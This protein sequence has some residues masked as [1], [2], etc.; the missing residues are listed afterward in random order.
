MHSTMSRSTWWVRRAKPDQPLGDDCAVLG[1]VV[2]EVRHDRPPPVDVA[3]LGPSAAR[4]PVEGAGD[5]LHG[6]GAQAL[7]QLV[8]DGAD[9]GPGRL[10]GVLGDGSAQADEGA[11]QVHVGRDRLHHLGF[12]QQLAQPEPVHRVGLHDLDD[13]GREVAPDVAQ[14]PGDP[15]APSRPGRRGGR[16]RRAPRAPRRAGGRRPPA[17]PVPRPRPHPT[18]PP[19]PRRGPAASGSVGRV[20]R[21]SSAIP[22]PEQRGHPVHRGPG[23]LQVEPFGHRGRC[24]SPAAEPGDL[25]PDRAALGR[26]EP[27]ERTP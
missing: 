2:L 8:G 5:G 21:Q 26:L 15:R 10:A 16:S 27:G 23:T 24:R 19:R 11:D 4:R 13:A 22:Q 12:E 1:Q 17:R 20:P 25:T 6:A 14:P 18:A 3:E 9:D 7:L